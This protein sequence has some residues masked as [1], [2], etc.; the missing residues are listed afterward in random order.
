MTVDRGAAAPGK[1]AQFGETALSCA[2]HSGH[3]NCVRLLLDAG[4]NKNTKDNVRIS[5]LCEHF[6]HGCWFYA[7]IFMVD[8]TVM[9]PSLYFPNRFPIFGFVE[10][11]LTISL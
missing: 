8:A 3:A 6:F 11:P 7:M 5:P 2:A 4:A 10:R 9:I 1:Y